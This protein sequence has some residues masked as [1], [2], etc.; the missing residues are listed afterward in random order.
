MIQAPPRTI[1]EVFE[2]LPEGTLCQVISNQLVMSPASTSRHQQTIREIFLKL[3]N[4][5]VSHHLG[6]VLFAPLDVYLDTENIYQPDII[7]ISKER[8]HII[9]ARI[10]GAPDLIIEVLSPGTEKVDKT[11][12]KVVYK[13]K[14]VKEYWI[15]APVSKK[16]IGYYLSGS[17]YIEIPSQNGEII[18]RLFGVTINF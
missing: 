7:F 2:G 8:L 14:G 9:E 18:S 5:V 17:Q 16:V 11:D 4:H 10:N 3:N 13:K 12:K 1:F 6:E 15:V